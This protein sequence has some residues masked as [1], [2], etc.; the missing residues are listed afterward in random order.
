MYGTDGGAEA[1]HQRILED[2]RQREAEDHRECDTEQ[3]KGNRVE[4]RIQNV[5][6]CAE[7]RGDNPEQQ[8]S[9]LGP[10]VDGGNFHIGEQQQ[11]ECQN[12]EGAKRSRQGGRPVHTRN[13]R[14]HVR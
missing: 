2:E 1:A 6:G 8:A 9:E 3:R 10:G 14:G 7:I 5:L 13:R 11:H 12:D 4:N